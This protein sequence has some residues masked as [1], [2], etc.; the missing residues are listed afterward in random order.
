[1]PDTYYAL[2]FYPGIDQPGYG[3]T[4]YYTPGS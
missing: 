2:V 3:Q 1:M 4:N